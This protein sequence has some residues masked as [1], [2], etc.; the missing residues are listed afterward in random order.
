MST[1]LLVT[2]S[3]LVAGSPVPE[4]GYC[5]PLRAGLAPDE[6]GRRIR[7]RCYCNAGRKGSGALV[8]PRQ[9]RLL[10]WPGLAARGAGMQRLHGIAPP[11]D[12]S[13]SKLPGAATGR[14]TPERPGSARTGRYGLRGIVASAGAQVRPAGHGPDQGILRCA[15]VGC[16]CC[17]SS[18]PEAAWP[19][20]MERCATGGTRA[21]PICY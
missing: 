16:H 12:N 6:A 4:G 9:V 15:S 7:V 11:V 18:W 3:L 2:L 8:A 20:S 10:R 21:R 5:K 17:S 1:A 19:P 14:R 13:V